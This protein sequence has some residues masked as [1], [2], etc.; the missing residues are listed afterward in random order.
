MS[1]VKPLT[2]GEIELWCRY[3]CEQG[4]KN[5]KL[6]DVYI[7]VEMAF[8]NKL[9]LRYKKT[10]VNPKDPLLPGLIAQL[11]KRCK[12]M[13]DTANTWLK[14]KK[15]QNVDEDP[16]VF[17]VIPYMFNLDEVSHVRN[18]KFQH[19]SNDKSLNHSVLMVIDVSHNVFLLMDPLNNGNLGEVAKTIVAVF[20]KSK[21][22]HD[23]FGN[24]IQDEYKSQ[25]LKWLHFGRSHQ[26]KPLCT[27]YVCLYLDLFICGNDMS[28]IMQDDDCNDD[29]ISGEFAPTARNT[30]ANLM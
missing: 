28:E 9:Y 24:F 2:E 10:K 6:G 1:T 5:P 7:P 19:K 8:F 23:T 26:I 15:R 4:T 20:M 30:I 11:S 16:C 3:Q 17:L 13:V 29:H 27:F 22:Y 25:T 21:I 14:L 18:G 12:S